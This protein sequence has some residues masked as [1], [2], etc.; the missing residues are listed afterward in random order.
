MEFTV[1]RGVEL[2]TADITQSWTDLV[3]L[4]VDSV[5]RTRMREKYK[6]KGKELS[7]EDVFLVWSKQKNVDIT[8][9]GVTK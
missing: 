9:P 4:A 6:E 5:L 8:D 1:G 2:V 3:K 7:C